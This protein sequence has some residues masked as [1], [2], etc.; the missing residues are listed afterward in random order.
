MLINIKNRRRRAWL[1]AGN[2]SFVVLLDNAPLNY[3]WFN[4]GRA[5]YVHFIDP[6]VDPALALSWMCNRTSSSIF[7][8]HHAGISQFPTE[9]QH[10][11]HGHCSKITRLLWTQNKYWKICITRKTQETNTKKANLALVRCVW[12]CIYWYLR[13]CLC[14]WTMPP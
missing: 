12:Q 6:F 1:R 10:R 9:L 8:Y 13:C 4:L 5:D 3:A 7:L 2:I 11:W 14:C